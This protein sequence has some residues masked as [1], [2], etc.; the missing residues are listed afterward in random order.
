MIR[1]ARD[2]VGGKRDPESSASDD[3]L[4]DSQ[5][6]MQDQISE[7]DIPQAKGPTATDQS[8]RFDEADLVFDAPRPRRPRPR[9]TTQTQPPS[10]GGVPLPQVRQRSRAT[11]LIA[12]AVIGV[13]VFANLSALFFKSGTETDLTVFEAPATTEA[14]QGF[15]TTNRSDGTMTGEDPC[16]GE[17]IEGDVVA[18]IHYRETASTATVTVSITATDLKGAD[19]SSYELEVIGSG[20][21]TPG[22][23]TFTF[24]SSSM[25][26]TRDDGRQFTDQATLTIEVV[27][28]EIVGWS[29]TTAGATC[30]P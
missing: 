29:Y 2:A 16:T 12:L 15:E 11:W 22:Q 4:R 23:Q 30:D 18:A 26:M 20:G 8:D 24:D 9:T 19:G 21:G 7:A 1:E 28:E 27:G 10:P 3:L 17:A 5:A 25:I 13:A 6:W 14:A